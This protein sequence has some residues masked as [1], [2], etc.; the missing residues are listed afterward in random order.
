MR[1]ILAGVLILI[2]AAVLSGC[3]TTQGTSQGLAAQ[4]IE[5][6]ESA[7]VTYLPPVQPRHAHGDPAGDRSPRH[8][9]P[10]RTG[11]MPGGRTVEHER[12]GDGR[13][14]PGLPVE[15][16]RLLLGPGRDFAYDRNRFGGA[17]LC[18]HVHVRR[19]QCPGHG[20][21]RRGDPHRQP[22]RLRRGTWSRPRSRPARERPCREW[23]RFD[24]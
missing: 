24:G 7:P 14:G 15:V 18:R 8:R 1:M 19:D 12:D 11:L 3:N 13:T 16:E 17:K 6:P 9:L 23:A 21:V 5:A 2:A 20:G 4:A 10:P 22:L